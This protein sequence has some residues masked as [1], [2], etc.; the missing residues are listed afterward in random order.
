MELIRKLLF[1]FDDKPGPKHEEI[2]PTPGYDELTIQYHLILL[3][4]AG[5]LRCEPVTSSTSDR[6]V[7][8]IPF[9]LTW[10]G[11]EFL[12]KIRSPHIWDEVL[13]KVKEH[14]FTSAS[15]DFI[16]Q[17]ADKAIRKRLGLD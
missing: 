1:F 11:H 5:Y 6:I 9:D 16:K 14:G 12:D 15:I 7:R 2:P 10:D 4:E 3:Y 17:L 13:A 8:V